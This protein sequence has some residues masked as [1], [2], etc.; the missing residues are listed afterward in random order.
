MYY[1]SLSTLNGRG[2]ERKRGHVE[3]RDPD[4]LFETRRSFLNKIDF[5]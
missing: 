1:F 2:V 4:V 3:R 5:K